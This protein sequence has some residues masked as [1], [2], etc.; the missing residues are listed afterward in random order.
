MFEGILVGVSVYLTVQY[1]DTS[2]TNVPGCLDIEYDCRMPAGLL[3]LISLIFAVLLLYV[4]MY[5]WYTY[6]V[7]AHLWSQP[8]SEYR[9]ANLNA[10]TQVSRGAG[11]DP[12]CF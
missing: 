11:A 10:R 2:V 3:V 6:R 1:K 7:F 5:A 9:M 4:C 12:E 8:Y